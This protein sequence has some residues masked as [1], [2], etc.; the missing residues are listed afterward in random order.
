M[1]SGRESARFDTKRSGQELDEWVEETLSSLGDVEVKESGRISIRP[2]AGLGDSWTQCNISGRL[3]E[4]RNGEWEAELSYDLIV[5]SQWWV[6]G[7][8]F[9]PMGIFIFISINQTQSKLVRR[10][11]DALRDLEDEAE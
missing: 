2:H 9:I 5:P 4:R 10:L 1:F 6:L 8:L 7:I 11:Q 3:R